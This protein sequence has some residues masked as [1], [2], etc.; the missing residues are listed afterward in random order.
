MFPRQQR[1]PALSVS[2]ARHTSGFV[3]QTEFSEKIR[4]PL[5]TNLFPD[6]HKAWITLI[7]IG[8]QRL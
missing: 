7:M 6:I 1:N 5:P 3:R 4:P 8:G 2:V